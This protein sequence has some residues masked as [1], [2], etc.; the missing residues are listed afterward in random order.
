MMQILDEATSALAIQLMFGILG[1]AVVLIEGLRILASED[2]VDLAEGKWHSNFPCFVGL[3][4]GWS[5][6][7]GRQIPVLAK[8][9]TF[10][11]AEMNCMQR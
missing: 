3:A 1:L 5:R 11:P 6:Y 10:R 7:L 4:R 9:R 8:V 2:Q